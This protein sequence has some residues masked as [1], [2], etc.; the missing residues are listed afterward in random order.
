MQR[1]PI[2]RTGTA[3]DDRPSDRTG[4]VT[5]RKDQDVLFR[6]SAVPIVPGRYRLPYGRFEAAVEISGDPAAGYVTTAVSRVKITVGPQHVPPGTVL[7]EIRSKGGCRYVG[8]HGLWWGDTGLPAPPSRFVVTVD[9]DTLRGRGWE[10]PPRRRFTAV[11][12]RILDD[13]PRR[14]GLRELA[15]RLLRSR[16]PVR[17]EAWT[18]RS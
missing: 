3:R 1:P 8:R 16:A 4:A 14:S 2:L 5:W 7:A 15:G 12:R 13:E 17:A 6:S 10:G 18:T 11:Y 9:G